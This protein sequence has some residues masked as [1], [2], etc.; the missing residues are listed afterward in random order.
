LDRG[1]DPWFVAG[2]VCLVLGIGNSR[3][4]VSRL[5]DDEKGVGEIDTLGGRQSVSIISEPGLYSLV[6]RSNKPNAKRFDR[7]VRHDVLPVGE[8]RDLV[9][10]HDVVVVVWQDIRSP[11]NVGRLTIKGA[12]LLRQAC[13]SQTNIQ[14]RTTALPAM[15]SDY[16]QAL[17]EVIGEQVRL[18]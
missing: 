5:D 17:L 9:A 13:A 11:N 1:G 4:A 7:W 18:S 10:A 14:A 8:V 3:D 16:A 15:D 6:G 12:N 2:D